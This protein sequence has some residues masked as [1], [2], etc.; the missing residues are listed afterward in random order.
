MSDTYVPSDGPR[1]GDAHP[2]DPRGGMSNHPTADLITMF[3]NGAIR[4]LES[5]SLRT[6]HK[7]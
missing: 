7:Q 4:D 2:S 5:G 3:D 1:L 6:T